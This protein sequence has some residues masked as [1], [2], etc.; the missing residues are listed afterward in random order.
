MGLILTRKLKLQCHRPSESL[1][2]CSLW[3]VIVEKSWDWREG[4][5]FFKV[6]T[7]VVHAPIL[8]I[9]VREPKNHIHPKNLYTDVMAPLFIVAPKWKKKI[10]PVP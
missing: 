2:C 8:G 3:L 5:Y 4:K 6:W 10:P 7:S 9:Y 1:F